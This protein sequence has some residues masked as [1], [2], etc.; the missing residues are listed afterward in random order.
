VLAGHAGD[1]L[2]D[3]YEA[4]RRPVDARNVQ[5]SLE[6]GLNHARIA[7]AMGFHGAGGTE[8]NLAALRSALD[9]GPRRR[10][11]LEVIASQSMEFHEHAVEYGYAY[12]SSA[13]VPDGTPPPASGDDV[14]IYVPGTRPGAPLPHAVI[15][16]PLGERCSTL[17]LVAPGRF[18]LIAGEEGANWRDAALAL[19]GERGLPLAALRIGH[20]TG[21]YRD[22]RCAWL[23]RR[24]IGPRG[25]MLVRPD[26]FVAWRSL[27]EAADPEG[28]LRR[29]LA[30]VLGR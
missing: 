18:L 29:A 5:R 14:R 13:V 15:E 11:V 17:D 8:A 30:Q 28:E 7:E 22:P 26:R 10:R 12:A 19:A 2:L 1:R 6:N 21:E 16:D 23:R 25:A 9:D 3:S 24:E 20:A 4:E 27:G